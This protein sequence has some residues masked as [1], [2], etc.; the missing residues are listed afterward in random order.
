MELV[1][2]KKRVLGGA[3]IV[4]AYAVGTAGLGLAAMLL[5]NWKS[6]LLVLYAP[7][8]AF[9]LYQWYNVNVICF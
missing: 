7:A 1:G 3:V 9:I 4:L 6:L 2:P 5:K 8:L